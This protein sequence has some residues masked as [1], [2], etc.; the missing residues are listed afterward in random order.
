[1]TKTFKDGTNV[2]NEVLYNLTLEVQNKTN[3]KLNEAADYLQKKLENET[4]IGDTGLT[5]KSWVTYDK[6]KNVKYVYNLRRAKNGI[7]VVNL[8]EYGN[9]KKPFMRKV[10][11]N[12]Q[13][14]ITQIVNSISMEDQK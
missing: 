8:L 11:K 13:S 7:P 10:F 3:D 12:S 1:M 9:H 14:K 6:Y 2:I 4:P 5:K